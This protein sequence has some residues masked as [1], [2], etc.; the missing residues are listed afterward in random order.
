M[1]MPAKCMAGIILLA[2][3]TG[4]KVH[5]QDSYT[6]ARKEMVEIQLKGRG[7]NNRE[8]L[9]AMLK[10]KRHQ[11]VPPDMIRYAY[12]DRP[13][14]IGSD[15]TISQPYIVAFMTESIRPAKGM[16]VLE[17]GTGSGYQAAVLAEIVDSVFTI[18][19]VEPLGRKS[20]FLL[21]S[22]GYNNVKVRIGDGFAGW[23]AHAPYDAILVTAAAKEVPPPLFAQLKE[24]GRIIIPLGEPYGVQTLYQV[25]KVKGKAHKKPLFPVRFVPFTRDK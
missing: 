3:L 9:A 7:I 17:I 11:F 21:K 22:L 18:E 13:L 23:P 14:P 12:E 6:A 20:S 10:V 24:G 16:K 2:L 5:S 15:Q 1:M 4:E 19:I 8:T 25:T